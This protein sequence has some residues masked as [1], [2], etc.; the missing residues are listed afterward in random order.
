MI[1]FEVK[2]NSKNFKFNH[3][4]HRTGRQW[5]TADVFVQ[6]KDLVSGGSRVLRGRMRSGEISRRLH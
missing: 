4:S 2:K 3:V 1:K 6:G 5:G